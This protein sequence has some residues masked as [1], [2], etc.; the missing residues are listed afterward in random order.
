[1]YLEI[2]RG[3]IPTNNPEQVILINYH[4]ATT[5]GPNLFQNEKKEGAKSDVELFLVMVMKNPGPFT[6]KYFYQGDI[7]AMVVFL[8]VEE[9]ES[10]IRVADRFIHAVWKNGIVLFKKPQFSPCILPV[11]FDWLNEYNTLSG[12]CDAAQKKMEKFAALSKHCES[13]DGETAMCLLTN[14]L[15]VG[16]LTYSR[17]RIGYFP[18]KVSLSSYIDWTGVSTR[19]VRSF[20]VSFMEK[21]QL[22]LLLHPSRLWW[23]DDPERIA[24][25]ENP[26]DKAIQLSSFFQRII[27]EALEEIKSNINEPIILV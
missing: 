14:I 27:E 8:S 4:L 21:D 10:K 6:F 5:K 26:Y 18:K 12:L 11:A 20:L 13:Q 25:K 16:L 24:C 2:F 23:E 1:M 3:P 17:C 22:E 9:L 7:K 19:S 15:E